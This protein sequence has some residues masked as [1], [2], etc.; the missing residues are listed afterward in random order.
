[1]QAAPR[2]LCERC[3]RPPNVCL[4]SF[5]PATPFDTRFDIYCIQHPH[6]AKRKAISSIPLLRHS[7]AKF[8]L[9]I[10]TQIS[11]LPS[12]PLLLFPG[13]QARELTAKDLIPGRTLLVIDG[14]WK[15]AKKIVHM[16]ASLLAQ[17]PRVFISC[18]KESIY[19][20]LRKEP[21]RGCVSTLEAVAE[22]ISVMEEQCA[23]Q[24]YLLHAFHQMV[25]QQQQYVV[26]GQEQT[27]LH[28][29]NLP[30]PIK[31]KE[32]IEEASQSRSE[33]VQ[34]PREYV[35]YRMET[36]MQG[37]QEYIQ[38]DH[39]F[40]CGYDEAINICKQRNKKRSRGERYGV[41]SYEK[42]IQKQSAAAIDN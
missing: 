14:T 37:Q 7:L 9:E 3:E 5:L 22:A 38:V 1:M 12:L 19:G 40:L 2:A 10:T 36:S 42:F 27:R 4:C 16:N 35:M 24:E 8:K 30:K 23:T 26:L 29:D 13:P 11:T 15:E 25:H 17:V 33:V 28:Y 41:L 18:E 6:E 39:P 34:V 21:M 31:K 20:T 32:P